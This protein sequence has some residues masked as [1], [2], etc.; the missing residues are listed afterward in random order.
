MKYFG[1]V[2]HMYNVSIA[3]IIQDQMRNYR[4]M[5]GYMIKMQKETVITCLNACS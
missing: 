2:K 5:N 3:H 4:V 1:D